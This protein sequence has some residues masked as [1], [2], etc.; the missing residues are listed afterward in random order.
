MILPHPEPCFTSTA[1]ET[2]RIA[3]PDS[4]RA[5]TA[6]SP[7][8]IDLG[9]LVARAQAEDSAAQTEL[10][11]RYTR[12]IS[13]YVRLIIR[14]P[15]AVED[16]VQLVFIKMFR[17]LG[18]LR[19]TS[20]FESW[21]FR[22]TRNTAVDFIRRRRCRPLTV[23]GEDE[24]LALPDPSNASTTNEIMDAL[25]VA[26]SQVTE[27]DR[28]L[29]NLFVQGNSY[30]SLARENGLS[31]GA[32]KARLHRMRPFLRSFVGE[33]TETRLPSARWGTTSKGHL[34]A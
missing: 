25:S 19:E 8:E 16:V 20:S 21:L 3:P 12:R 9:D 33:A 14:Q 7:E 27:K 24:L 6:A 15:D 17:R 32:V 29:V 22:L 1:S 30:Q 10:V 34:A 5:A 4:H 31:M 26:L 2:D 23:A 13:G 18:R 28:E 11:R